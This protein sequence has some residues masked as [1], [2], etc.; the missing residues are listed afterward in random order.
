MKE[1]ITSRVGRIIAGSA[2]K[3]VDM[4]ENSVPKAVLAEDIR[5]I[6][7]LPKENQT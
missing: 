2:H 6:D 5:G 7:S 3:I 1:G 4:L